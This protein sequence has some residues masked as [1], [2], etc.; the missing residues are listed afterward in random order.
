VSGHV[1][2]PGHET[3][4]GI[5]VVLETTGPLTVVGRYDKRD[6]GGVHLLNV[7]LHDATTDAESRQEFLDRSNRFGIRVDRPHLLVPDG[8]VKQITRLAEVAS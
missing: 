1:F 3:L 8:E 2:H 4:H 5:T 7:S 6:A